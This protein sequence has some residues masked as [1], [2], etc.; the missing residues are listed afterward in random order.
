LKA[1]LAEVI[2]PSQSAFL[3]GRQISDAIHL[4]QELMHNYHLNTGPARCALKIDLKK[5]FDTVSWEYILAGLTAIGIPQSMINWINTCLSTAHYTISINGESHGFFKATRGIRQG[6]PLSPYLFVL[7]MEGLGG[8]LHKAAQQTTFRHHWRCK[9]T[10][11]THVCFADDLMLFCHADIGSIGVLRS[12]LDSFTKLSGLTINFAKSSMYLSGIDEGMQHTITNWIGIEQRTLPVRYLGIPLISTRLTNTNCI[13]LLERITSRIKLWTSSSL[14]YA[15]RLQLIKSILFSIQVYWSSIFI[16][17]C[18]TLRKI[19]SLLAAFLWRGTSL[20]TSGA[21]VA[22]NSVCYPMQ[23]GG[24]GIKK[25]KDW[26]KAATLKHI[27]RLLTETDSI[28]TNWVHA[29]LLRQKSFWQTPIP[30]TPSWTWRK[31]LQSRDWCRGWFLTGVGDGS[32]TSLWYDYWLPE[33]KRL[34]DILPLRTLTSTGLPWTA[35]VSDIIC[36]GQWHF[37]IGQPA[38]QGIWDSITFQPCQSLSDNCIWKGHTSGKF[39]IVSAWE[40]LRDTRPTT[41]MH[42]LLWFKGHI[43][44]QSFILW[45]A[46]LGRLRTMDRLHSTGIITNNTC[47]LCG[48]HV[49]THEHLF[50]DCSFTDS[51]WR[52]INTRAQLQW[53]H[54]SWQDLLQWASTHYRQQNDIT[55]MIARLLLSTTVYFLWHERNNRGFSN[56][57]R[58]GQ[59]IVE[60]IYQL[61]R[62]HLTHMEHADRIPDFVCTVWRLRDS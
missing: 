37:P 3:P 60:E 11:I 5:A 26:N 6:D 32:S 36:R 39:S 13:P 53:P 29:V 17:P 2:G 19:E 10:N 62:T 8:I 27:W 52:S 38:L 22:W 58:T 25:L 7:A 12:S 59:T 47:I 23:E 44:R 31:I 55:H 40:L 56:Q 43:P 42:H 57:H 9:P 50:F 46:C 21:K 28:W 16:L 20:T 54:T 34:I 49:E 35:K 51:V 61:I 30:S 4:T 45:L 33:G 14:T 48:L 15:G 24:L 18:S 1:A 41:N